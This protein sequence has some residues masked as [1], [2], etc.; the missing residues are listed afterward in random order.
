MLHVIPVTC[1]F[2]DPTV[3]SVTKIM[4][5]KVPGLTKVAKKHTDNDSRCGGWS[6]SM[7]VAEGLLSTVPLKVLS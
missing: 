7:W 1:G 4:E 5:Q 3:T 2:L 6:G